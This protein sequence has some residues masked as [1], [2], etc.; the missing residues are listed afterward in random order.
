MSA[1][2]ATRGR[3]VA[4]AQP[5]AKRGEVFSFFLDTYDMRETYLF[6]SRQPRSWQGSV[7]TVPMRPEAEAEGERR[8]HDAKASTATGDVPGQPSGWKGFIFG[9]LGLGCRSDTDDDTLSG[10]A[11]CD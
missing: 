6:A 1:A 11:V 2:G 10:E 4:P 7:A 8:P 3:A 9:W 5:K